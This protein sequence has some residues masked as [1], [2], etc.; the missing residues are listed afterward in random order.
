MKFYQ[1]KAP[2][3]YLR[4]VCGRFC[5]PVVELNSCHRDH[6]AHQ[7]KIS[8]TVWA[9]KKKFADPCCDVLSIP[10]FLSLS[11][12]IRKMDIVHSVFHSRHSCI[13]GICAS[14]WDVKTN[15][16]WVMFSRSVWSGE[17]P[18]QVKRPAQC[19]LVSTG[20][21]VS[22][23][24]LPACGCWRVECWWCLRRLPGLGEG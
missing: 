17:G 13:L 21:E 6:L 10:L 12:F 18:R 22:T 23:G 15:K 11:F 19:S 3:I 8:T 16:S 5:T 14:T 1:N 20:P 24:S 7:S 2:L 4:I 9:F